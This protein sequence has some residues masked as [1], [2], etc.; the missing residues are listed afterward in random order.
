M[1]GGVT[2][3]TDRPH[4]LFAILDWGIGHATRTWPLIVLA[5]QMG[6]EVTIATRGTAAA[7]I[8]ARMADWDARK[9]PDSAPWRRIDK[10]GVA[11]TYGRGKA[12]RIRIARQMPR[13]AAS[14]RAERHWTR[15]T[16][17][18]FGITHV[19]S[20]NCYGCAPPSSVPSVL[21][22]HQLRLPVPWVLRPI[23][24]F[25][26][27]HWCRPFGATWVPD[28]PDSVLAGKLSLPLT[29]NTEFVGPLSRFSSKGTEDEDATPAPV[30]LGLVSGP[31]PQRSDMESALRMCFLR[32]GRPALILAGRP[33]TAAHQE[34]NVLTLGDLD[35]KRFRAAVLGAE[36]IVCRS[37][38]STLL[39][40][41]ALKC[42]ATLVPTLGQP[43]QEQLARHW[44][45]AH[46]WPT[47]DVRH[48]AGHT[49]T[50]SEAQPVSSELPSPEARLRKWLFDVPTPITT[51]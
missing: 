4:I 23:A 19:F 6:A 30:L 28:L 12:T 39:D 1:I 20:D 40:L 41:V 9:V 13:F 15:S 24:R 48:L 3:R 43:E 31:E 47:L 26:V 50:A 18:A 37:G 29:S 38:Y 21:L 44:R 22:T 49:F 42:T 34:A 45:S 10:P 8:D 2:P 35:D 36:H 7:W 11:I 14:I 46:G 27:R 32:D 5:R 51:A 17:S 16:V 33:G 25:R